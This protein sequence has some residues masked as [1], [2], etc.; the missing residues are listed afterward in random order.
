MHIKKINNN[1]QK[2]CKKIKANIMKKIFVI[3]DQLEKFPSRKI[4]NCNM[5]IPLSV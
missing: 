4:Y 5:N 1:R 3:F 2:I